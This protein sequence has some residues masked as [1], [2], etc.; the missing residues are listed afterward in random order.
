[1][2]ITD[3]L[4]LQCGEM[5][6]RPFCGYLV[7]ASMEDPLHLRVV[8]RG[9]LDLTTLIFVVEGHSLAGG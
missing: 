6:D 2:M 9:P 4:G 8:E 3:V 7:E 5:F 1:M